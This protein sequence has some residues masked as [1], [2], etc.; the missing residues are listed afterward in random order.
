LLDGVSLGAAPLEGIS[1]APGLHEVTFIQDG[2]RSSQ[3]LTI[4][5]GEHKH[6]DARISPA[7]GDGLDESAVKRTLEGYRGAV[8]DACWEHAFGARAPGGPTSVR[9]SVKISVEPSGFVQSV[10]TAA[11]P[12]GYPDL[13]RCIK[14]RVSAWRFPSAR[15]ETVVNTGFV[16]VLE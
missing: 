6:V 9:V 14:K 2:E 15:A 3:A 12:A 16:F 10:A 5:S 8:V 7:P 13:R 1:V 4:R 11:D